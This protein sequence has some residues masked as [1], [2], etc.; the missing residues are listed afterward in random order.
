MDS[1]PTFVNQGS[2]KCQDADI[3]SHGYDFNSTHMEDDDAQINHD[4]RLGEFKS[5]AG[6]DGEC[7]NEDAQIGNVN[8]EEEQKIVEEDEDIVRYENLN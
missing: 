2:S 3:E 7:D 4:Y 5:E 1:E 6:S 8:M